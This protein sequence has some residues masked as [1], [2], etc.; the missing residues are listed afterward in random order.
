MNCLVLNSPS[1]LKPAGEA[2]SPNARAPLASMTE[3][4]SPVMRAVTTPLPIRLP[5]PD[6]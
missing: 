5:P 6:R 2:A 1:K 4:L 3:P